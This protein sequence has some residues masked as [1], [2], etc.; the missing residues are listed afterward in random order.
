MTQLLFALREALLLLLLCAAPLLLGVAVAGLGF[1]VL[2]GRLLP[3]GLV[4]E[5]ASEAL[6]RIVTGLLLLL[7]CAPF[8]AQQ[9]VR[10]LSAVL[11]LLP[12]VGRP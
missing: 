7:L 1:A 12:Q 10:F 5:P 8:I 11:L 4:P 2:K 6:V 3:G 9:L